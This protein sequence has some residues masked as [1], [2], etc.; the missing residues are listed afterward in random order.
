[1]LGVELISGP[2]KKNQQITEIQKLTSNRT[3]EIVSIFNRVENTL[4]L[5]T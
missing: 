4:H 1:M 2:E 3:N 5:E